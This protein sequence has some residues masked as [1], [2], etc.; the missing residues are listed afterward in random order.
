MIHQS[1]LTPQRGF[2]VLMDY[3]LA[4]WMGRMW[5]RARPSLRDSWSDM[6]STC[7]AL[8][9]GEVVSAAETW[10][11]QEFALR[12]WARF[13]IVVLLPAFL[14]IAVAAAVRPGQDGRNV[15]AAI[16]GILGTLMIVGLAQMG[17]LRYRADR[18]RRYLTA[19]GSQAAGEPLP[20]DADGRPR[21]YDF[22]VMLIITIAV[23]AILWF[24]SGRSPQ[25]SLTP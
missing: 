25:T 2:A 8:A 20:D 13:A 3:W 1:M 4:E 22:W 9:V 24:A 23:C 21:R 15:A 7:H 6:P 11:A 16:V 17:L 19:A 12:V 14:I 5:L 10:R 18:T